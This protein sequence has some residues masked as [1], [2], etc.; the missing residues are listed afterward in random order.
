MHYHTK[1]E[2]KPNVPLV[3]I[4]AAPPVSSNEV[5]HQPQTTDSK[6][7]STSQ[8]EQSQ[9]HESPT[10]SSSKEEAYSPPADST[11]Q[12]QVKEPEYEPAWDASKLVNVL[13]NPEAIC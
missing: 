6:E 9:P 10:L 11:Q 3:V 2:Y 5:I 12:D 1:G 4:E 7:N 8:T 13:V